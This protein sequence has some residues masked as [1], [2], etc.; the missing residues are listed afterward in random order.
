MEVIKRNGKKELLN[1]EKVQKV[2]DFAIQDQTMKEEFI[3]D[4]QMNIKNNITTEEIQNTLIRLATEKISPQ[5]PQW[6]Y[7][8]SKLL[9]YDLYKQAG[10]NRD[11]KKFGYGNFYDIIKLLVKLGIYSKKLLKEYSKQEI[12]DLGNYIVPE[13]DYLFSYAGLMIMR[14]RYMQ[15]G[16]NGEVLELPQE[17]FMT[18]GM[19]LSL[20]ETNKVEKAKYWYDFFSKLRY[21]HGT[22]TILNSGKDFSQLASCFVLDI[23]DE[24]WSIKNTESIAGQL[25]KHAGGIGGYIGRIRPRGAAIQKYKNKSNGITP[26][27]KGFENTAKSCNQLG[28]RE[29]A[30]NLT[31]EA[32][33]KDIIEFLEWRTEGGDDDLK[34][35]KIHQTISFP[36]LFMKQLEAK[37][38]W[39]L[40]D[41]HE[42]EMVKGYRLEEYFCD[43][44]EERYWDC[45]NDERI[46]KVEIDAMKLFVHFLKVAKQKGEP[47]VFFRDNAHRMNPNSHC[48]Y[49]LAPNLCTEVL[50]NIKFSSLENEK[51]DWTKGV[52]ITTTELGEIVVC[53]IGSAH[54]GRIENEKDIEEIMTAMVRGLDNVI[55][56]NV[57]PT[58]DAEYT[59]KR[60]RSIG[61]GVMSYHEYLAKRGIKWESED[62]I[63]AADELFE[64]IAY[65]AIKASMELAKERG[66]Y[67][68]YEGSDWQTGAYFD[69]RGYTSERW[70]KLKED[71]MKYGIRNGYLMAVAPT[72]TISL[73]C[74]ATASTDP[75]LSRKFIEGK[76]DSS[77]PV[78]APSLSAETY[79]YYDSAYDIDQ[80][81]SVRAQAARQRHIDQGNSFNIYLNHDTQAKEIFNLYVESWKQG[82]KTVYY[83][84]TRTRTVDDCESCQ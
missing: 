12:L 37:G 61:I 55:D 23:N 22:P 40:L 52:K 27:G 69:K 35:H 26:W 9:V 18:M 47:F 33:G 34:I 4:L 13:R 21:S 10:L 70:L 67:A 66:S 60:Y 82:L 5:Q 78:V 42:I 14:K 25:S 39:Y 29:G 19:F 20:N 74:D 11:Y 46:T 56:L 6:T 50:N 38:K 65:Y 17:H 71:V 63:K 59:S 48:G 2:I 45:V 41:T 1:F 73:L 32:H 75:I 51:I 8:A 81:W 57:Y 62:H 31:Y 44:Y 64:N 77:L 7:I 83:M 53:V 24:L 79:W 43:E 30:I 68:L 49:I 76:G 54:V 36:D 3:N 15:K 58:L 16:F 28:S 80:M 72:G 84:R